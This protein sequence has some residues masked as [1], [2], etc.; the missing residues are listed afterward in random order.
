MR[1]RVKAEEGRG[2]KR[3]WSKRK[4][5]QRRRNKGGNEE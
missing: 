3:K 2:E 4:K 5:K 1:G